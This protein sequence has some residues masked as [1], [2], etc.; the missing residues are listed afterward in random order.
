MTEQHE[1]DSTGL[2]FLIFKNERKT[3]NK[4]IRGGTYIE[5]LH[6]R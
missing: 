3:L 2:R 6:Y 4:K 5:D 1:Y